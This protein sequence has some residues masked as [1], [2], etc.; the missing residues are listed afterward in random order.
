VFNPL[1]WLQ[2][3]RDYSVSDDAVLQAFY[4]A[5]SSASSSSGVKVS[6]V[7]ALHSMAVLACLIVRAETHSALPVDVGRNDGEKRYPAPTDPVAALLA[8]APNDLMNSGEFWRWEDMTE[9]V[10][11]NAYAHIEWKGMTPTAIWPLTGA[12]PVFLMDQKTR[13]AVYNYSG[14]Y[15]TPANS[16]PP[17]DILHF[18]GP[19]LTSPYYGRSLIDLASETIGMSIGSDQFFARLLGNGNHFP[20]YLETDQAL[21]ESDFKAISSQLSGFSGLLQAGVMR[22]FDRGLK[23]KQNTMTIK[24]MD[25]TPQMRWQLQQICSVFRVPMAL[26]QDLTNGTYTNSEQQDL[27][28]AKHTVA[29]MCVNKERVVRHRLFRDRPDYYLKFNMNALM[30]G[31]FK[32]RSEGQAALVNAGV[33]LPDEA[34]ADEDRNPIPAGSK[35]RIPLNTGLI[36]ENGNI[37]ATPKVTETGPIAG[38]PNPVRSALIPVVDDAVRWVR[39]RYDSD[40]ERGKSL[41]ATL[42]FAAEKFAPIVAAYERAGLEF[43]TD[44]AIARALPADAHASMG[45]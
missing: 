21:K 2:E 37:L 12:A 30:R 32:T 25:L 15:M 14:D 13:T 17:R 18:K 34:R 33:L 42:G 38:D 36:D 27:W 43:D 10:N 41:E 28:L 6:R 40:L 8:N 5:V 23:Y 11:G 45:S 22:I 16:Y 1:R 29:P 39:S 19:V 44:E 26:V 3:R 4:G 7:T 35:P 20:G 9:D 31:D 24:D